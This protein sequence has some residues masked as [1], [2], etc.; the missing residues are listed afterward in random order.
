MGGEILKD[1]EGKEH[2]IFDQSELYDDDKMGDKLEDFEVLQI[3]GNDKIK[4][5]TIQ[6]LINQ[7]IYS[8]KTIIIKNTKDFGPKAIKNIENQIEDYLKLDYFNIL[9]AYKYFKSEKEFN[10]IMEHTN[11]R[12]LKDYIKLYSSLD[13]YI[14]EAALLNMFLQCIKALRFL[15]SKKII[16]KS[17]SPK[18][19]LMTNEKIIKLELCPV[20]DKLKSYQPPEKEYSEKGDIY[21]LGCVFYQICFSVHCEQFSNEQQKFEQFEKSDTEYSKELFDIIKSMVETDPK[22]RPSSEELYIKIRDL[23]DKEII[24][25][26]SITS[27]ISCLYSINHLASE[28]LQKKSKF[29]NKSATPISSA[30]FECLINIENKKKWDE[31]IKNF[32]RYLGTKN[33]KLD[34][35]KEFDPFYLIVFLVENMQKELNVKP[36]IN[37]EQGYLI[38]RKEDKTNKADMVINFF[39]YFK[40]HFNSVMSET[41]F[42]IMKNK[43]I[44]NGCGLKTY[45]FNS[46]CLLYFDIDKLL[47][48]G[49]K[50]TLQLQD[51]FN[52]LK[53]GQLTSNYKNQFFCK[54]CSTLTEHQKEKTIYYMPN[55]LIIC[56]INKKEEY[57]YEI[58]CPDFINLEKEREYSLSPSSFGLRGFIYKT[59]ENEKVKYHSY[60]RS[61]INDEIYSCHNH[62]QKEDYWDKKKGKIVMVFYG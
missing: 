2:Y 17:I 26:S 54:G 23:Y 61:P 42:G 35:E 47:M 10:I 40:E 20:L 45:S 37:F 28:F 33:P 62:I 13:K 11:N 38:K 14:S 16:H 56:F 43:N 18:H 4:I 46:F 39:R 36:K 57:Q 29:A 49:E 53:G 41:F 58:D 12:S 9:K 44:C 55:S 24:N 52:E 7:K 22:K 32:R 6:S 15:H 60:F 30:F 3:Y 8:M 34:S 21:S 25:N 19:F 59:V 48:N 1:E 5:K 50:K 31:N 51:F 27:L